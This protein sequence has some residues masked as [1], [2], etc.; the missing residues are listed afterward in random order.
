MNDENLCINLL[1]ARTELRL[2]LTVYDED[3]LQGSVDLEELVFL[4]R[5]QNAL[6]LSFESSS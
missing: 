1:S 4:W 3:I 5:D 2:V 6:T